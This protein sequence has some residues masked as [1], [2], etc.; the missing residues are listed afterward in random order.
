M[1]DKLRLT[2]VTWSVWLSVN[3]KEEIIWVMIELISIILTSRIL[4]NNL[5]KRIIKTVYVR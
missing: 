5:M 1:R 2:I 3:S 4:S